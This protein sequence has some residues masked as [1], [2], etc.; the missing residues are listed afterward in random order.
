LI[1]CMPKMQGSGSAAQLVLGLTAALVSCAPSGL[2]GQQTSDCVVARISDGDSFRCQDGRRIRLIGIDTPEQQQR[3]YGAQSYSALLR[4]APPGT[5]LKLESDVG[6]A[7]RYGRVL[8]YAW[9]DTVL[10][11]EAMVKDGWAVQYTVP[12]NVRYA[13][14]FGRAQKEARALGRGLWGG[15]AFDCSPADFRRGNCLSPP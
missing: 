11:N 3:P 4:M 7:D 15:R 13:E 6:S 2:P 12:P 10:V 9:K 5:A 14:R 8:A 1:Y